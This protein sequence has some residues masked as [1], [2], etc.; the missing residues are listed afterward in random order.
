MDSVLFAL[1]G[2]NDIFDKYLTN[3][4]WEFRQSMQ[5][6]RLRTDI[7]NE[8][9]TRFFV[10]SST[11]IQWRRMRGENLNG[12]SEEKDVQEVKKLSMQKVYNS[13]AMN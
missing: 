9:R 13:L 10:P 8:L 1:F 2:M 6:I 4:S 5:V 3:F 11:V 12:A 7:V